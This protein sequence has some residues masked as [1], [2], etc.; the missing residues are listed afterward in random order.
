MPTTYA[1]PARLLVVAQ[2]LIAS[3][4][5]SANETSINA[6]M[7]CQ[8][9]AIEKQLEA[10]DRAI[11]EDNVV[12]NFVL[13]ESCY[14]K[15]ATQGSATAQE[16]LGTLYFGERRFEEALQE[17][18]AAAQQGNLKAQLNLAQAYLQASGPRQDLTKA[19]FWFYQAARQ[20]RQSPIVIAALDTIDKKVKRCVRTVKY[21]FPLL[22]SSLKNDRKLKETLS[23]PVKQVVEEQGGREMVNTSTEIHL[24]LLE[25]SLVEGL[26][27]QRRLT[28]VK[29][30]QEPPDTIKEATVQ[31]Q[32]ALNMI[33][34][35]MLLD[36]AYMESPC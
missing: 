27:C 21:V 28:N 19:R 24:A 13:A 29:A 25:Q 15:A 8:D 2:L 6:A 4:S 5:A 20:L 35:E 16:K 22:V 17:W 10:G 32:D 14:Q 7:E 26:P 30:D 11:A 33:Y 36:Q 1:T 23:K 3:L 31:C 18:K 9:S 34:D 12:Q